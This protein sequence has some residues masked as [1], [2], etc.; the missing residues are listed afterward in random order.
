MC[1]ILFL[2]CPPLSSGTLG[3][4]LN[5]SN[6]GKL[7]NSAQL[8]SYNRQGLICVSHS[9]EINSKYFLFNKYE[10]LAL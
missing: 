1:C 9:T 3:R 7:E 10:V 2:L 5:L 4:L 8:R 6:S